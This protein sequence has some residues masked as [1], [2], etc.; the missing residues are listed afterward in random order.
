MLA[1]SALATT[2]VVVPAGGDF[3]QTPLVYSTQATCGLL[4][5]IAVSRQAEGSNHYLHTEYESLLG[6]I[7][8]D[9]G[10]AT[11][12]SP[13]FTWTKS[14]PSAV[15]FAIERRGSLSDLI[16]INSGVTFTVALVDETASTTT[17]IVS[18]EL[19]SS[20]ATFAPLSVSVPVADIADGHTYRLAIG[21]SFRSLLGVVGS[22]SVDVDNAGLAITPS[23]ATPSIGTTSLGTPGEHSVSGAAT[24][25]P[26]GEATTYALQYGTSTAYGAEAGLGAI[27][28]G[29]EGFQ[30][31]TSSLTGLQPNT[32]YHARFVVKD[33]GG[34]TFGEDMIFTTAALSPPSVSAA[35]V[36][37]ITESGSIVDATVDPGQSTTG[38]VVEYGTSTSYGQTTSA[39]SLAGGSGAASVQIP[40]TSLAAST[41][42]HARVVA[43]NADGSVDTADLSFATTASGGSAAPAIGA[44]SATAIAER[45]ATLQ[46]TAD[47]HGEAATDDVEYGLNASY[48]STTAAQPIAAGSSGAQALSIPVSGLAPATTYHARVTV[49]SAAGTSHGLDVVFTTAAL[50]PPSVSAASVGSIGENGAIVDT[51]V[52]PGQN[53]TSVAVEYGPTTAYGQ[54]SATQSVGGGAGAST[55]HVPLAGLSANTVYHAR[56]TVTSVDG[57]NASQD[58]TFT[59]SSGGPGGVSGGEAPSVESIGAVGIGEHV[60]TIDAAVDSHGEEASYE[61]QYGPSTGYGSLSGAQIIALGTT[62]GSPVSVPLSGLQ[63]GTAYHA[64]LRVVSSAGTTTSG[65]V[66][67]TTN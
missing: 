55:V 29:E 41:T 38:V 2:P 65:D 47:P 27:P 44:T 35:S 48:G 28:A 54:T 25:D 51:I 10:T 8:T 36:G 11:I 15:T 23:P 49:S 40:L 66:A 46:T 67:F 24:I 21:E 13:Q 43:T 3:E 19:S 56:V 20:Q 62:A 33:A 61:V 22:A 39:Q 59:T 9:A 52:V 60:A 50:S 57:S 37:A 18:E 42:Y 16:G 31:V 53:A 17:S 64:R 58:V 14:T 32:T 6:V 4:C 45:S 12:T 63:A 5:K 7:G 34:S 30:Q 1:P 26:H